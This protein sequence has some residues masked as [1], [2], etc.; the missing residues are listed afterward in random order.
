MPTAG[1]L[2][3]KARGSVDLEGSEQLGAVLIWKRCFFLEDIILVLPSISILSRHP[4]F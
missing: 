4:S 3:R 2:L 1:E